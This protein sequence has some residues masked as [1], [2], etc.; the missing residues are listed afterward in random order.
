[1]YTSTKL[2]FIATL[3]FCVQGM[4]ADGSQ[5]TVFGFRGDGSGHYPN[6]NPPM[7]WG[8]IAKSV[9]ELSAQARKPKDDAPPAKNTGIVGGVI[10]QWLVLGPLT[11][12]KEMK[13]EDILPNVETLSP[14]ENDK[15]GDKVWQTVNADSS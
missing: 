5:P 6:A 9:K 2:L 4:A 15:G 3:L 13:I 8:R 12:T 11:A 1:M 10:R 7:D 14:D